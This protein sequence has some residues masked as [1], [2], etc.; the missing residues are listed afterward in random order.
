[1]NRVLLTGSQGY[2]GRVLG[3]ALIR[4]DHDVVGLDNGGFDAGRF[5]PEPEEHPWYVADVRDV[6]ADALVGFDAIVHLAGVADAPDGQPGDGATA[7]VNHAA[8]LRLAGLA[9][10]AGVERFVF[11][12]SGGVYGSGEGAHREDSPLVPHTAYGRSK[13]EAEAGL[14]ALAGDDFVVTS[15]RSAQLYGVSPRLRTDLVVN[16]LTAWAVTTGVVSLDG[17]GAWHTLAHVEDVAM[18][19]RAVLEAPAA[20]VAGKA[21]NVGRAGETY[22]RRDLADLVGALTGSEVRHGETTAADQSGHTVDCR[23]LLSDVPGIDYRWTV[24]GG[25]RGLRPHRGRPSP[26]RFHPGRCP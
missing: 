1:M 20:A 14:A 6:S 3:P 10:Q 15:L 13:A 5:G 26:G 7:A 8:T 19:F 2:L 17:G 16:N 25:L 22:R 21:F 9:K 24:P 4:A 11:A 23:L 18:A 12:S